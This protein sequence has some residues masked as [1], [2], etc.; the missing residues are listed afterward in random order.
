MKN[1]Y[2]IYGV[3]GI[4]LL[5]VI[6]IVVASSRDKNKQSTNSQ[7]SNTLISENQLT[8]VDSISHAHGLSVDVVDGSKLYIA[9]HHGLLVLQ[10]DSILSRI[11][12][13]EDDLM[14]FSAHPTNP[15]VYF[16]SGHPQTGGNL[17]FQKS[18]DG[19]L[20]WEKISDG[21]NGP[22]D[23][24][25]MTVSPPNP[26]LIYGTF[27]GELQRT[28]DEGKNWEIV[29]SATFPIVSLAADPNDENIVYAASQQGLMVST[30]KGDAWN[31]LLDDLV[32]AIAIHPKNPQQVLI[33]SQDQQLM[34]SKDG[35]KSWEKIEVNFA[36]ETPLYIAFNKKQPEM[37]YLLT[38]KNSIY[39]STDEGISWNKVR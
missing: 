39:K 12:T 35:G 2:I 22:V 20:S 26:N 27:M 13:V 7:S 3:V 37:L 18:E 24:H 33:Y 36:Q 6:G 29:K 28:T 38:D 14:G 19:G 34:Q 1:K 16:S 25:T 17:G 23:Y 4:T 32:T 31:K 8:P 11:G 5:L 30:N 21:I 10:N 15:K 9:T